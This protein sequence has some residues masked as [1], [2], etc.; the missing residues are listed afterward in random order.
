MHS[1]EFNPQH[2]R[3]GYGEDC[4]GQSQ[5]CSRS[6]KVTGRENIHSACGGGFRSTP[7][8][9]NICRSA[10]G[11]EQS[12]EPQHVGKDSRVGYVSNNLDQHGLSISCESRIIWSC[13]GSD[14]KDLVPVTKEITVA[15]D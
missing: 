12:V 11:E 2:G 6:S 7:Q 15:A 14:Q 13:G 1:L 5:E 10:W 3:K 8:V 4:E 9:Q